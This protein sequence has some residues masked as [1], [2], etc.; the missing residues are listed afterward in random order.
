MRSWLELVAGFSLLF[1]LLSLYMALP[2]WGQLQKSQDDSETIEQ[3][4]ARLIAVHNGESTSHLGTGESLEAHRQAEVIDHP[5]GSI[6]TDKYSTAEVV[7]PFNLTSATLWTRTG[8]FVSSSLYR[9]SFENTLSNTSESSAIAQLPSFSSYSFDPT[10]LIVDFS[11]SLFKADYDDPTSIGL[12][13]DSLN[14]DNTFL[15]F[16]GTDV[17]GRITVDGT[18]SDTG[19]LTLDIEDEE[20]FYGHARIIYDVGDDTVSFYINDTLIGTLTVASDF[21]PSSAF[22]ID[23]TRASSSSNE[24]FLY[25]SS[26]FLSVGTY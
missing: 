14:Q 2:N 25:L 20:E 3:A 8:I 21:N 17:I 6:P 19:A 9:L 15:Y 1:L 22:G 4:I 18:N 26:A 24:N 23:L 7:F 12:I 5:E 10:F 16:D 13:S 11:F